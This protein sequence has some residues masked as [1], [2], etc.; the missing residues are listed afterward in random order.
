MVPRTVFFASMFSS[1]LL[2]PLSASP[3]GGRPEKLL[4]VAEA[5]GYRRTGTTREVWTFLREVCRRTGDA[6]LEVMGRSPQGRE[7]PL[8]VAGRPLP[9]GPIPRAGRER[10]VIYLQA[11]IHAG[12]VAGKEALQI[13]L[14]RILLEGDLPGILDQ[15]V[16][17]VCPDF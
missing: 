8:V 3:G 7:I 14:R 11:N 5:S 12:E 6:R 9:D 2:S 17:L 10:P 15:V 16:L 13:L 4:T 1:F